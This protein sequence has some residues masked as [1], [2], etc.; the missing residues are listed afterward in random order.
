[1]FHI[2][3]SPASRGRRTGVAA[4]V[5]RGQTATSGRA[6]L[7]RV[8]GLLRVHGRRLRPHG[9]PLGSASARSKCGLCSALARLLRLLRAPGGSRHPGRE[10]GPL[11]T[12]HCRRCSSTPAAS[13]AAD[14]TAFDHVGARARHDGAARST[15]VAAAA[16]RGRRRRTR[17]R[18][19]RRTL[20]RGQCGA[21]WTARPRRLRPPAVLRGHLTLPLTLTP[22]P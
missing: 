10:A 7:G 18:A 20:R 2:G 3:A 17:T 16:A 13:T 8:D 5:D 14:S 4:P 12:K 6:S 11:G 15:R 22:I 9:L 21:G 1:M 19:A